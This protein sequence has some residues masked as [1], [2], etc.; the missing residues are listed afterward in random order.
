MIPEDDWY[1]MKDEEEIAVDAMLAMP[2]YDEDGNE[3]P[4]E[5][6]PWNNILD[7]RIVDDDSEDW[8]ADDEPEESLPSSK[9]DKRRRNP[10]KA[11]SS[12]ELRKRIAQSVREEALRRLELSA[13]TISEFQ[14]LVDWYDRE[15]ESRMRRER[16]Y[17]T[18]R[19]DVPLESGAI[20]GGN[21]LPHSMSQPTFRQICRGEFDDYLNTCL[22]MMHDLTER[23]HLRE[24]VMNLKLDHKEIL[25]FLGIRLYSTHKL[26]ELRGQTE[27]NIRKVRDTVQRRIRR[28][29]YAALTVLQQD[30]DELIH[31]EQ[32]FLRD[33]TPPKRRHSSDEEPV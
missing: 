9:P 11:R 16:R 26:A 28:K 15:E 2:L 13:R 8:S 12:A 32:D 6:L 17:E 5:E 10:D 33:Y 23:A 4:E 30:G 19:G 21:I 29:L 3:I 25:F 18:L 1:G 14:E 22:F 20:P 7:E 31:L 27:R 24:I